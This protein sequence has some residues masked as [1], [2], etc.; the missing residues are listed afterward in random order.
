MTE[1]DPRKIPMTEAKCVMI[2]ASKESWQ[3]F[4]EEYM[5]VFGNGDGYL[6]KD[7]YSDYQSFCKEYGYAPYSQTKFGIKIKR[8]VNIFSK[9]MG[10]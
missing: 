6:S 3:L 10:S 2:N 8:Y 1:F 7:C 9:K 5:Y 4:F